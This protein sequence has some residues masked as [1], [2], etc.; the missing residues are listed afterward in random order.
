MMNP[1][2]AEARARGTSVYFPDRAIHMLPAALATGICSL[3]PD[4]DRLCQTCI[5]EIDKDKIDDTVL[6]LLWLTLH[7]ERR[8]WKTIDYSVMDRLL[9]KGLID[10][11]V[12]KQKSV[13]LT[14]EGRERCERLFKE[15]F[16]R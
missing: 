2:D 11:P 1:L 12:G 7:D 13:W 6:A 15:L 8:A 9:E 5:M 16:S 10:D 3:N 4:V 14:E